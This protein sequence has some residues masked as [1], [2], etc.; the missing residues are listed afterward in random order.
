MKFRNDVLATVLTGITL[1]DA[2]TILSIVSVCVTIA[3]IL[4]GAIIR[5]KRFLTKKKTDEIN[6]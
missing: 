3:F 6:S 1:S 5:W 2:H 4:P